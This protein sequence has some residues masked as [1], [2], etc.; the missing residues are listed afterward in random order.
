MQS[1]RKFVKH[2]SQHL[3]FG[4]SSTCWA[5]QGGNCFFTKFKCSKPVIDAMKSG[6]VTSSCFWKAVQQYH[7]MSF[8]DEAN[9]H[10]NGYVDKQNMYVWAS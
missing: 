5:I 2:L 10:L 4:A 9:F 3:S 8:S 1:P 6:E 7:S